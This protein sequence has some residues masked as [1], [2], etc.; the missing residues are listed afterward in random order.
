M[1]TFGYFSVYVSFMINSFSLTSTE[2]EVIQQFYDELAKV[3]QPSRLK[4]SKSQLSGKP[5]GIHVEIK[6]NIH[7]YFDW[8]VSRLCQDGWEPFASTHERDHRIEFRKEFN[9]PLTEK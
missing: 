8:A 5:T 4:V 2:P 3:I 7:D 9:K 6:E 1:T